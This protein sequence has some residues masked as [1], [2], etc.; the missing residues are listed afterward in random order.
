MTARLGFN[1]H[2]NMAKTEINGGIIEASGL[3]ANSDAETIHLGAGFHFGRFSID[4]TVSERWLKNGPNYISGQD[5][6]DLFGILS[7]SYN[8]AK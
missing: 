4:A 2:I 8:F 7:A 1:K 6:G 3:F 5:G